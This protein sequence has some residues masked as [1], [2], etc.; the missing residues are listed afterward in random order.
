M[1]EAN[2][3]LMAEKLSWE[4]EAKVSMPATLWMADSSGTVTNDSTSSGPAPG[5]AVMTVTMGILIS[6]LSLL[7]RFKYAITPRNNMLITS[8]KTIR[9]FEI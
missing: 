3:M 7:G 4:V 8:N 9:I 5:R 2:W 6:G 1:P